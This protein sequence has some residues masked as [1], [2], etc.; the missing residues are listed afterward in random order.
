MPARAMPTARQRRL[1]TEVRKMRERAGMTVGQGAEILGV[2]RTLISNSEAGRIGLSPERVRTFA[3][4]YECRDTRYVDALADM[5][6]ERGSGWWEEYRGKL[7]AGALD[8]AELEHHAVGIRAVQ[9]MHVAGLLQTEAYARAVMLTAVPD[10][11]PAQLRRRL[12]YRMR[13]RDVLDRE[14]PP[15]CTF[16]LHEAALRM[17]FGGRQVLRDQLEHLLEESERPNV[18]V[19]VVPFAAGGIPATGLA[20][21][22]VKGPV[23]RLDTVQLGLVEP[24]MLDAESVLAKHRDALDKTEAQSLEPVPTRDYVRSV[25]RDL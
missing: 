11:E 25:V 17:E 15:E 22:Y 16:I 21:Q 6:G 14:N 10:L 19:R 1:G 5:A 2:G 23:P 3:E 20:M 7:R 12:S 13:R 9:I 24:S 4:I 18:V 8:L